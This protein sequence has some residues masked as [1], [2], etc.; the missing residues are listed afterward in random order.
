MTRGAARQQL[1]RGGLELV[2]ELI[3]RGNLGLETLPLS[4]VADDLGNSVFGGGKRVLS[5]LF[6]M[7]E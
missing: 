6:P 7:M 4:D 1:I 2:S 3:D 5:H